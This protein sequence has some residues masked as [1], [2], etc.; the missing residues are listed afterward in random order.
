MTT[1][2]ILIHACDE[3]GAA[4]WFTAPYFGTGLLCRASI[5]PPEALHQVIAPAGLDLET[6]KAAIFRV[7]TT[8]ALDN[9]ER[10]GCDLQVTPPT[11][12]RRKSD[13]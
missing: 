1:Y 10:L 5:Q 2:P 11:Y 12:R 9:L 6:I 8:T 4:I 3:T 7:D 13:E